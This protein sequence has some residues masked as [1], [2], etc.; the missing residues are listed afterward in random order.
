MEYNDL[1]RSWTT[2]LEKLRQENVQLKNRLSTAI[3]QQVSRSF[4]DEAELFQQRFI[5]KD[6]VIDLLR[7]D[8]SLLARKSMHTGQKATESSGNKARLL[9]KDIRTLVEEFNLMRDSFNQ[10]LAGYGV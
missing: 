5:D 7:H 1:I 9:A 2:A 10:C 6:Q 3:Q 8:I 4:L